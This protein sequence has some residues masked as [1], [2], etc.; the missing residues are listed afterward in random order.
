MWAI[1]EFDEN[2]G[3]IFATWCV[4]DTRDKLFTGVNDTGDTLSPVSLL[5]PMSVSAGVSYTDNETLA[6]KFTC[7]HLKVNITSR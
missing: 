7:L 2:C 3:D 6:T 1:S 4:T 5:Q